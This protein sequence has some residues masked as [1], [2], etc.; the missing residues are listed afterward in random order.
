MKES[1]LV[2]L[3]LTAL[4][5]GMTW[6]HAGK[7]EAAP[8]PVPLAAPAQETAEDTAAE[9]GDEAI[10]VGLHDDEIPLR[11]LVGDTVQAMTMAEYLP[12]VVQGEMLP[13]FAPAA[14]AAQAVAERTY[15][16][17]QLQNGTKA[18][19]P[20]ADVCTD[21]NCCN[22]YLSQDEARAKWGENYDALEANIAA[23]V[24]GTDGV[25]ALYGG[26][27]IMAVFH[28]SSDGVTARCNDVW[29][30]DLPYLVSV[31]SP[32]GAD[33]VPNYYSVNTF[34][35][36]EFR[37][38]FTAAHPEADF[39]GEWVKDLRENGSGRVESVVIGG[40]KI[41]RAHV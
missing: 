32:E 37:A 2:G 4:L 10:T 23:A 20:Q 39:S 31:E 40:V 33:T 35:K 5:F 7:T 30:A 29:T 26:A 11:V 17:Y 18:R 28:S 8:Q 16:C 14:L 19:H 13:S 1:F 12:C 36:D 25:I 9:A 21:P 3:I 38:V 22:A 15:V 41:G 6:L 34:S 24:A 27:P